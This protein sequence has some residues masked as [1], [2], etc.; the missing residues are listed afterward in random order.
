MTH[1]ADS[2]GDDP[3]HTEQQLQNFR[4]LLEQIRQ[5]GM[6][7]PIV[8]AA[9]SAAIVRFPQS[10]FSLGTARHH[11]V[12]LPYARRIQSP[13]PELQPVLSLRTTVMQLRTIK[14][15]ETS[16]T[17]G[18]SSRN[19]RHA[20]P[21]CRSAMPTAIAGGSPI[22]DRPDRGQAS[23]DRRS[24]LHGYDDGGCDRHPIGTGGRQRHADR[25]AGTRRDLGR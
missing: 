22:G 1:L 11:A 25:P 24:R 21:C 8:H 17:T 16:A 23:P 18:P 14:P 12:R 10:H 9:N 6:T 13:A 20:L 3:G 15:G 5:R 7:V 4:S 2:D 19:D